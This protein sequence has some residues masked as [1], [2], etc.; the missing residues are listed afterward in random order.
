MPTESVLRIAPFWGGGAGKIFST[1]VLLNAANWG[2]LYYEPPAHALFVMSEFISI[3]NGTIYLCLNSFAAV[4]RDL[5]YRHILDDLCEV[6]GVITAHSLH[7]WTLT[8]DHNALTVHL[9]IGMYT[10][11]I[12]LL[13]AF[14]YS[15]LQILSTD[16][17]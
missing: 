2:Q 14:A 10:Y 5:N 13:I 12:Y 4:P 8:L 16:N 6:R 7:I 1:D 11:T 3:L 15:W 9:A 17:N